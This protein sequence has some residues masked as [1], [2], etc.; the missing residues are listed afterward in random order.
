[1]LSE[2]I[3]KVTNRETEFSSEGRIKEGTVLERNMYAC[4]NKDFKCPFRN[5]ES[6][7]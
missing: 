5:Q 1:M 3:N 7:T 2:L 6:H 4:K